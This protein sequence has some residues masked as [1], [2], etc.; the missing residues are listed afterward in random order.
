M[1]NQQTY[2]VV[3][4]LLIAALKLEEKWKSSFSAE[5]LVVSAW[6]NFPDTFGIRGFYDEEGRLRFPDSNRV[7][8]E[9]MGSKPIRRRGLLSK[10]GTK[11]YQLTES[12]RE[13][14][15]LLINRSDKTE[16]EKAGLPREIEIQLK[17]LLDSRAVKK[18]KENREEEISFFDACNFW[19]ISPRSSSIEM[20]SKLGNLKSILNSA[21]KKIGH[22][23]V[24]FKHSG[25]TFTSEDLNFLRDLSSKLEEIFKE[26]LETIRK[27]RDERI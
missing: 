22:K 5:D 8:A 9:I 2:N 20:E 23:T 26:Q 6:E 14:A 10:I 16:I 12:G 18:A 25:D 4:K 27:R 13:L 11:R 17:A 1:K 24:T 15:K 21:Y 3:E 7:F 19:N